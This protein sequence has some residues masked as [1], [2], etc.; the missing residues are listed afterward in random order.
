MFET[1]QRAALPCGLCS[2]Q[3]LRGPQCPGTEL[4]AKPDGGSDNGMWRDFER[5]PSRVVNYYYCVRWFL[6]MST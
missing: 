6:I 5:R 2:P 1:R 3:C 4:R